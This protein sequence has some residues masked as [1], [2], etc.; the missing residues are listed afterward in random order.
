MA[1]PVN[2][3]NSSSDNAPRLGLETPYRLDMREGIGPTSIVVMEDPDT[4][5]K[6]WC[7]LVRFGRMR[8]PSLCKGDDHLK[9][10]LRL[11]PPYRHW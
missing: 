4:E 1:E 9:K 6:A 8:E 10:W 7:Q 11:L 2:T 3:P 5:C